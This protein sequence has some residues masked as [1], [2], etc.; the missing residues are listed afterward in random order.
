MATRRLLV[1]FTVGLTLVGL[2]FG[3]AP[4]AEAGPPRTLS[5]DKDLVNLN[6]GRGVARFS[7]NGVLW[8]GFARGKIRVTDLPG[9]PP[10][11]IR[12]YGAER[13]IVVDAITRIYTGRYVRFSIHTGRWKVAITARG[14]NASAV[15]RG[16]MWLRGPAGT[17]AIED[18][19]ARS[20]PLE[21]T[22][23]ALGGKTGR[24]L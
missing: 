7:G 5:A 16:A 24:V 3:F 9:G 10:T 23:F 21:L 13:V 18:S 8:G 11:E 20:W 14:I 15:L 12:V 1:L 2:T 17:Y 6:R 4:A 19:R 22:R